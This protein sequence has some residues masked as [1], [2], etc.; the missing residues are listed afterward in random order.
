VTV[1]IRDLPRASLGKWYARRGQSIELVQPQDRDYIPPLNRHQTC[2]RGTD[3]KAVLVPS[4]WL[5]KEGTSD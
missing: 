3:G 2:V 5:E 1:L 4:R